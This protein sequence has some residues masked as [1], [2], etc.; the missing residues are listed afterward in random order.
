MP[1]KRRPLTREQVLQAGL[2]LLQTDGLDGLSMRKLAKTL[3]VEAMSL[4]NHVHDRQ[5]LLSGIVDLVLAQIEVPNPA[6]LWRRRLEAFA[7]RLYATLVEHPAVVAALASEQARPSDPVVLQGMDSLVAALAASGLTPRQQVNAF[8]GLLALCF[9]F[10][11]NHTQGLFGSKQQAQA[12][13]AQFDPHTYDGRGLPHLARL[14][15][16]M[17]KTSADDDFRFVL[18]AYLD[19]LDVAT[20]TREA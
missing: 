7:T 4:Y 3:G 12:G 6:W 18:R 19:R 14:A 1:K 20:A 8:R 10:V 11:F 5:D 13:W 17:L 15:P 16:F 2:A 9:G